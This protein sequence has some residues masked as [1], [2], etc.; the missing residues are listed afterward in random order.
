VLALQHQRDA[1][2]ALLAEW[3]RERGVELA[4]VRADLAAVL[5]EPRA[6]AFAA[7]LGSNASA[8]ENSLAWVRAEIEWLREADR[9]GLPVLGICFGAQ[10]LALALGGGVRR[11]ALL[12]LGWTS[13]DSDEPQLVGSGPWFAWHEDAIELPA[14]AREIARNA[15]G[16]QAFTAG[17]HVGVQFHP[18]V[19]PAV[20]CGWA[21]DPS[22]ARQLELAGLDR[23]GLRR[24]CAERAA[25]ARSAAFRLFD[26]FAARCRRAAAAP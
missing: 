16:T 22:G 17:A 15:C 7:V 23:A 8:A 13:V 24:E 3:A 6:F 2:P 25:A 9:R 14:S 1:P 20:A 4:V 21:D 12:E 19:T 18:E 5:P 10:A 26:A 11:R